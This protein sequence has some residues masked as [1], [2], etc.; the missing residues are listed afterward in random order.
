MEQVHGSRRNGTM[1]FDRY[2][3]NF[4]E[5]KLEPEPWSATDLDNAVNIPATFALR[6]LFGANAREPFARAEGAAVGN[7]AHRW[8]GQIL[9]GAARCP[10]LPQP[11]AMKRSSR[12]NWR[13]RGA[14]WRNGMARRNWPCR[15]GGRPA[16]ARRSGPPGAAC[17][18][19]GDGWI[20][21]LRS[22]HPL[23]VTVR[24]AGGSLPLKGRIDI[25]ISDSPE[26]AGARVRMFDFKT[27][28]GST[29]TLASLARGQGAQFA[30]YYLMARDAGAA[31]VVIGIIKP[32]ERARDVFGAA[33]E[34][35]LRARFAL[36][37]ELR[38]TLRFGRRGPLVSAHG[39]CET[40]PMATVPIDPAILE[41]KAALFLIA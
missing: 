40:L 4:H 13:R 31:E 36:L 21:L 1:P 32:E 30:A 12:A 3:F 16:F 39:V 18:R 38:R 41:Q 15:S 19:R 22:E 10:R 33:D 23:A 29:P 8:L 26:I 24:T 11:P 9:A 35:A 2:K 34:E 28:R 14:N 6:E 17:G 37:A 5:T 27:G 20:Q 7:R 25:V